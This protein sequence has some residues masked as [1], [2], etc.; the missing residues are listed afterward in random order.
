MF[1]VYVRAKSQLSDPTR[2]ATAYGIEWAVGGKSERRALSATRQATPLAGRR[3][4]TALIDTHC[5]ASETSGKGATIEA[6]RRRTRLRQPTL[7]NAASSLMQFTRAR[8]AFSD[9]GD[10]KP[11]ARRSMACPHLRV[12]VFISRFRPRPANGERRPH[13]ENSSSRS[14]FIKPAS[15]IP[16]SF[17]DEIRSHLRR[18]E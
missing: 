5:R 16:R 15:S 4:Q 6:C 1:D 13:S 10:A 11:A 12:M 9:W 14:I 3:S 17:S 8:P 2:I 18:L 7:D